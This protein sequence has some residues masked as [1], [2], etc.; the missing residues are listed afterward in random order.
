MRINGEAWPRVLTLVV[1][2]AT[3]ITLAMVG[4][5]DL[6]P[7]VTLLVGGAL[8]H[9]APAPSWTVRRSSHLRGDTAK[10]PVQ[11]AARS[12]RRMK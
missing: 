4:G 12:G 5:A 9:A 7:L 10:L 1:V 11:R 8:G 3:A 2:L 6:Y